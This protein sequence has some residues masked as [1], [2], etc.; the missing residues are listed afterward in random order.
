MV[1]KA[2][3]IFQN[4][5][6][7]TDFIKAVNPNDVNVTESLIDGSKKIEFSKR[8]KGAGKEAQIWNQI[9]G[10]MSRLENTKLNQNPQ[11][12]VV[13]FETSRLERLNHAEAPYHERQKNIELLE[14]ELKDNINKLNTNVTESNDIS[15]RRRYGLT[16][17]SIGS[18]VAGAGVGAV[19]G[20]QQKQLGEFAGGA[21]GSALAG[22][23]ALRG[24]AIGLATSELGSA[25]ANLIEDKQTANIVDNAVS[26]G[27]VPIAEY[28]VSRLIGGA[29]S[30]A[31]PELSLPLFVL[32]AGIGVAENLINQ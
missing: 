16:P 19:V 21:V 23:K 4:G 20:E 10:E 29:V 12:E 32:G 2:K 13:E 25:V 22:G 27:S 31:V 24:G 5:G 1:Q 18:M 28:G 8:I 3:I 15:L 7:F 17:K 11:T 26:L 6:S 9:G 30:L 14:N